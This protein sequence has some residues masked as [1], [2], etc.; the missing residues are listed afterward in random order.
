MLYDEAARI[1]AE[2]VSDDN[3]ALFDRVI[4]V[5]GDEADKNIDSLSGPLVDPYSDITK[6]LDDLSDKRDVDAVA[7]LGKL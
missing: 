1:T 3:D 4:R 6:A 2:E 7:A 5:A